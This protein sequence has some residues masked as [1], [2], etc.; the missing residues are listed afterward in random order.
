MEITMLFPLLLL[1][2]SLSGVQLQDEIENE[3][4]PHG[5][6]SQRQT[7]EPVNVS[8]QQQSCPPDLHAVLREMSASLAEQRVEIKYLQSENEGT[9]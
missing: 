7:A 6:Q 8:T 2:C 1:V 3:I 5:R 4:I 9:V